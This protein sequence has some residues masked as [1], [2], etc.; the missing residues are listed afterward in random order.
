MYI[1]R[2]ICQ[3]IQYNI[4]IQCTR[5]YVHALYLCTLPIYRMYFN[6]HTLSYLGASRTI[7]TRNVYKKLIGNICLHIFDRI[8]KTFEKL[9]YYIILN[10]IIYIIYI[11]NKLSMITVLL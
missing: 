6:Y 8:F 2:Y 10:Y 3:Y 4:G 9:K 7:N 11:I 5:I 1:S